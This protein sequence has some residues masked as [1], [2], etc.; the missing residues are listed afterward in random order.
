MQNAR[1]NQHFLRFF[2][3]NNLLSG[4][5]FEQPFAQIVRTKQIFSFKKTTKI[6][7]NIRKKTV[8][9]QNMNK[10]LMSK[11]HNSP[12]TKLSKTT[13]DVKNIQKV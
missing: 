13:K 3:K 8:R 1:E 10:L 12:K 5:F 6:F 4:S 9:E 7:I 11:L 2:S